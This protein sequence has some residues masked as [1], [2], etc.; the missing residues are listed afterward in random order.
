MAQK[1]GS[2]I[3]LVVKN[4][5][6]SVFYRLPPNR[7]K[8]G[9]NTPFGPRRLSSAKIG[10]SGFISPKRAVKSRMDTR[11][12]SG[13]SSVILGKQEVN[14]WHHCVKLRNPLCKM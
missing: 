4:R 9:K 5:R 13:L 1:Y 11:I 7:G 14:P 6:F 3:L 12:F 10:Q 2:K 8:R